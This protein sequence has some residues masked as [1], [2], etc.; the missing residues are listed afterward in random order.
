MKYGFK[1]IL[2]AEIYESTQVMFVLGQYPWFNNMVCDTLK[3]MCV[4]DNQDYGTEVI[5]EFGLDT[6]DSDDSGVSSVD[7]ATFLEVIG[8]TSVNGKWFCRTDYS[9]L[10]NKQKEA[11]NNYIKKPSEN[12]ILIIVST[13]WRQFREI[14]R[15]RVL[16]V[17]KNVHV[18]QLSWPNRTV[19]KGIVAQSF[20]E[21]GIQ[22]DSSAIDFFIMRMSNA[23]DKYES[24]IEDIVDMHKGNTLT[25][26]ELKVYMKGI[27][28]FIV[29]DYIKEL[30]KPLQNANTNSKKVFKIM[31]A[32]EDE[33]GAKNLVYQLLKKINEY[34][35]FRILIN[36]GYIPIGINYFY[37]DI[38]EH[39]PNKDKYSKMNEWSFRNKANIASLTSLRDWEYMKLILSKAVENVKLPPDVIDEK[40]QRA[41]YDISTRSVMTADRL[42]NVVGFDNVLNKQFI[43]INKI[44]YD[45]D[46][47]KHIQETIEMANKESDT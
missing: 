46:K 8:V 29:D 32:L 35:E 28:N 12:G 27:E 21:R 38:I 1:D 6:D 42:N 5:E 15:N 20:E 33:F 2:N 36:S 7:F 19:L 9:L 34:I 11:L 3:S 26:K 31:I 44:I 4:Q 18:M 30:V 40:C 25:S 22:A 47:L 39:I 41:L 23:Y 24:Q 13:D 37:N 45:E 17:S 16:N 14:L 10:N 43:E